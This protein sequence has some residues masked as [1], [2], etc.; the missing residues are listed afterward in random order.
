MKICSAPAVKWYGKPNLKNSAFHMFY[1]T[2]KIVRVIKP[3]AY[4]EN[5]PKSIGIR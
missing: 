1:L 5:K 2:H 4:N 3:M